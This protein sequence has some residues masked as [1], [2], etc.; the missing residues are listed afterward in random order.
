[1]GFREEEEE[2]GLVRILGHNG[3]EITKYLSL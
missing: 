1:L 2:G 3:V